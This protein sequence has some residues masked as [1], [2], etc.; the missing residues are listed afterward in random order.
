MANIVVFLTFCQS[1]SLLF[2]CGL[3]GRT[4]ISHLKMKNDRIPDIPENLI[5]ASGPYKGRLMWN[6]SKLITTYSIGNIV[7]K[8]PSYSSYARKSIKVSSFL[9]SPLLSY[10]G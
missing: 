10:K 7:F 8:D 3:G 9:F 5:G 2:A 6:D 4:R 1:V